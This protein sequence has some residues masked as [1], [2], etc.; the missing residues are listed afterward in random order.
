VDNVVVLASDLTDKSGK[1]I[2]IRLD[3][4][5]IFIKAENEL[6]WVEKNPRLNYKG[7][8]IEFGINSKFFS[9]I[10]DKSTNIVC[11]G[12]TLHFE[13]GSFHHLLQTTSSDKT[14]TKTGE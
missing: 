10:L 13:N 7:E 5:E 11:D 4:G 14:T 3:E 6:G 2:M 9:Q 8:P 1:S 12:R